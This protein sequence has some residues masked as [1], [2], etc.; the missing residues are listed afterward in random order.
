MLESQ[1]VVS[2]LIHPSFESSQMQVN[3]TEVRISFELISLSFS[4][5]RPDLG[6]CAWVLVEI[7]AR[8]EFSSSSIRPLD[9]ELDASVPESRLQSM[10]SLFIRPSVVTSHASAL[11]SWQK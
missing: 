8:F 5:L 6:Q 4:G 7:R 1:N 3:I 9:F 2:L 11:E 10:V